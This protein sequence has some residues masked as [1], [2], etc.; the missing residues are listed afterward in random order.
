L[1]DGAQLLA[2]LR[3]A[4][5]GTPDSSAVTQR[6]QH[7]ARYH[8]ISPQVLRAFADPTAPTLARLR[9][10]TILARGNALRISVTAVEIARCLQAAGIA[11]A[12]VKGPIIALAYPA[13]DRS[14]IDVDVLVPPRSM[15]ETITALEGMGAAVLDGLS[16]PRDDGIGEIPL[17]LPNGVAIDLHADLVHHRAVRRSFDW[18]AQT[19][20]ERAACVELCGAEVMTLATEDHVIYVAL[21]AMLSGGHLL[22]WVAD[23][24]A[25]VR[26]WSPDWETLIKRADAAKLSL[27]VGVMLQRSIDLLDTPVPPTVLARLVARGRIWNALMRWLSRRYPIT[28][29]H[30]PARTG[31]FVFRATR[32]TTLR[33]LWALALG[34]EVEILRPQR[35]ERRRGRLGAGS[36]WRG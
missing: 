34:V 28:A 2:A 16:W 26:R 29:A 3:G 25:M 19:L 17:G 23:L 10:E 12:L 31:Q 21:H 18:P 36:L 14:F 32:T 9:E 33:S 35:I 11:Y 13:A 20:L 30:G 4:A 6:L 7:A 27:V 8:G 1:A 22:G 5:L 15:H 24:D